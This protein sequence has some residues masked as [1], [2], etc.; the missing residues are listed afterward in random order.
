MKHECTSFATLRSGRGGYTHGRGSYRGRGYGRG[1]GQPYGQQYG[2][3]GRQP[4]GHQYGRG[5]G[6][7]HAAS[8]KAHMAAASEPTTSTSQGQSKEEGQNEATFGNF[9]HY[10]YKDEG[11]IDR[12]SIATHNVNS[13]WILDSGA[14]KH[15]TG[16]IS[17]FDSYTQYPPTHRGTIQTADGTAQS[18]KGEGSVQCTPNIKLSSVLHVPAFPVNLLS[19]SALIDQQDYRIIVDRYMCVIQ[20]R[21]SSKKIGTATR[22]RGLWHIDR[23]KMGHEAS[24]VLAAIVGGKESMALVHHCRM[25]HMAFDKMFQ[26]FPDVMNGVDRTKLCCDACEYAKHTRTSYVSRGIR[27][28]SPFVLVHSDVWT[29]PVVSVSG[30]KYF[31]TFIDCYSRMTW[32]YLMRHKDEVF[33][34]FEIFCSY[35]KTQFNVQVQVIR[36]DN[37]TEYI[38][39]PFA[40]F[41]SSQG[42]LHQ[43]SCPDTPPQNGVA[44]RKNRHILEVAR[45]LMFT[46]NVPK[47]LWSEA[48]MTATYLINR[49]PSKI[50]GMQSPCQLLL[51]NNDFVVPPKLFGC[52]CFVR[53]HRP[54]VGKLD[55]RA[56]KCIFIGYS[57]RQKGYKCWSPTDRRTFVSM[58]VTFRESEPFYGGESD[59]SGLF[60]GL[61]HLGDAQ[62][63][64]KQIGNQQQQQQGG[65]QI[66]LQ[67]IPFVAEIPAIPGT[68]TPTGRPVPPRRWLQNPLVYSRRQVQREQVDALE[69]QQDQGQGE[70]PIGLENQGSTSVG[71]AEESQSQTESNNSL[72]LPIA[73]RKGIRKVGP[74][75]R[76]SYDDYDVGNYISYKALSPSFRAFVASLQTVSVP[77]DWKAARL[78][79]RWCNAMMEELE[80]LKKNK[81]WELT[82]LPKGKN[83]VGCKWIYSVKQNAEG[84][85]ERY[86]ARLVARGYSQTYGID[87]DETFAPVAKMST[88]R[89]LIS[90][91]ANFGWPLHQLDVKNAFLHGDL[92]EEVYMEM[93]PG[94]VTPETEGKVCRL[95]KSLYG[96]KQSPRAWFDRFRQV[97]C[98]MGYGQCNGD[99]TLFYRHSEKK[100]TILAVYV[101]DII[102][103]GDDDVEIAKLK[104]CLSQAFEVKDLG[105]LKYFLGIEVARSSKGISLS[106]RKYTLDLLDDVGMMGCRVASTPID[107]NSK[108]TAESGE[109]ID[110]EKYQRLVGRLIYLCHTRP[111][112]SFAVSVVSRYMHDPRDGHLEAAQRILRYL[113]GTPGKGLWFKSNGHLNVDGYCDADWAS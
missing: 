79:P 19:L 112:I 44:E 14:S 96:L 87:Y 98:G 3:G 83:A 104:G 27:S 92:Q 40:A 31:V 5:G 50:L 4:Y 91:A 71:S 34:C 23:D 107:Q 68:P 111:D 53:D 28:V 42:I 22:H 105:K 93:P 65:D 56:I 48:V 74:P 32:I 33:T 110:K 94:F 37:G 88:V 17:E 29:C 62:E 61:D 15:V 52:T 80:A 6:Q 97:V 84:K 45:S 38:N 10:V 82:Y 81:T 113:K 9:A 78:D 11:N 103:T 30:M 86:K 2:R 64:E 55:H 70:Q 63:G 101:D 99:H 43:T 47:F 106:Q 13:D 59:L 41:L 8:P 7:Q 18:I 109:P 35:V 54:S 46:M 85:V 100:I 73:I 24:S 51:N 102:I 16:N 72:D 25:G 108:I 1:G 66:Q 20:E 60:Q 77:K 95:K 26:V 67:Q 39:K 57:S 36:T 76:H 58:D 89:I 49:M 75:K 12:V 90:C 21:E 69:E